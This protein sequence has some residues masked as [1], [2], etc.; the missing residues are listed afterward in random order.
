MGITSLN[1]SFLNVFIKCH[2]HIIYVFKMFKS[3][4]SVIYFSARLGQARILSAGRFI[5]AGSIDTNVRQMRAVAAYSLAAQRR[6]DGV[7]D[8]T[9]RLD[10]R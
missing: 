9:G 7:F 1:H 5:Y 10:E 6:P 8:V 2:I 4:R 3:S